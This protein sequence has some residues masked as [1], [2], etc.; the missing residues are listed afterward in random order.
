[1]KLRAHGRRPLIAGVAAMLLLAA[2]T[3]ERD[4]AREE[5]RAA[6]PAPPQVSGSTPA[7]GDATAPPIVTPGRKGPKPSTRLELGNVTLQGGAD[8]SCPDGYECTSFAVEC[9]G[10]RRAGRGFFAAAPA[11]AAPRGT[12]VLFSGGAG[13]QWWGEEATGTDRLLD[14]LRVEGLEIVQVRWL[15]SWLVSSPGEAAGPAR[16]ACR[17]A[18]IVR[19]LHEHRFL[20]LQTASARVGRCGFCVTGNSGGASQVSYGLSHYGLDAILDAV[21]PT[22]GPPHAALVKGCSGD[23]TDRGHLFHP[24]QTRVIDSSYG[25]LRGG[26]PCERHDPAYLDS[27]RADAV[28]TGGSDYTHPTTRVHVILGGQD[29][30]VAPPHARDYAL[31]LR[32][33]ASPMTTLEEVRAMSHRL[34]SSPEGLAALREALLAEPPYAE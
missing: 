28:D 13:T 8:P 16:L 20:P 5:R 6:T 14:E 23:M 32:R 4:V 1:M 7:P 25:V 27:W 30:G 29:S 19:W 9:P 24:Q 3:P 26:G 34:Q 17:P 10:V 2:C 31:R 11:L 21:V 33:S 15:S 22:S 18:T 12:V